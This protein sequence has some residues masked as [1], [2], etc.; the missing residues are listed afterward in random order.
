[1]Y[2]I[3]IITR[4]EITN[5]IYSRSL[6]LCD[7]FIWCFQK[8]YM[9]LFCERIKKSKQIAYPLSTLT[10]LFI[11]IEMDVN[12]PRPK[13]FAILNMNNFSNK[14]KVS[15]VFFFFVNL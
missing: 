13:S 4:R 14:P 5:L 2:L 12:G 6:Q 8:F 11:F 9:T 10:K 1:M 3:L 15:L 7:N